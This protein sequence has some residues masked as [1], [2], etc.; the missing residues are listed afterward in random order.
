MGATPQGTRAAAGAGVCP[1]F[2]EVAGDYEAASPPD[3]R[4]GIR[5]IRIRM[6]R[7]TPIRIAIVLIFIQS[8]TRASSWLRCRGPGPE[9]H[10]QIPVL[11]S[12]G[13]ASSRHD[14]R[15]DTRTGPH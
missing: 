3:S 10:R 15:R 2:D 4:S 1:R 12:M 5:M 7:G 8:V 6:A 9:L 11:A 13:P 14:R